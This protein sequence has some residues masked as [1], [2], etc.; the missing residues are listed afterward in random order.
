MKNKAIIPVIF[1]IF[2]CVNT[3]SAET[4][5]KAEVD[6]TSITT[7]ETITYKLSITSTEEK[8]SAPELPKLEGFRVLSQIKSSS[9][10]LFSKDIKTSLI[11]TY[12]LAPVEI[13]MLKIEPSKIKIRGQE[14]LSNSFEIEVKQGMIKPEPEERPSLPEEMQQEF[15]E[16]PIQL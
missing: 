1:F 8:V 2:F 11:Y 10:S 6:K 7:D 5:I 16:K 15:Y 14:L 13:G 3:A 12:I 4:M 9:F